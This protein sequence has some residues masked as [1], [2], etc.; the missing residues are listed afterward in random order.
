[1]AD[2][3]TR[4]INA[5]RRSSRKDLSAFMRSHFDVDML[6]A[7]YREYSYLVDHY[8]Q[9][10]QM[11]S[12]A[13]MKVEFPD[14]EY[15]RVNDP[16]DALRHQILDREV[17]NLVRSSVEDVRSLFSD[18][19]VGKAKDL[20]I[21]LGSKLSVGFSDRSDSNWAD[22]MRRVDAYIERAD[23]GYPDAILTGWESFDAATHGFQ[24]GQFIGFG[25][26]P[27]MGKTW[28]LCW[29]VFHAWK[30]KKVPL[31]VS[32]EMS[33]REIEQRIDCIRFGLNYERLRSG[34]LTVAEERRYLWGLENLDPFPLFVIDEGISGAMSI[35][36]EIEERGPDI[37]FVDGV[38]LLKDDQKGKNKAERL[39]NTTSDLKQVA[40]R[41]MVPLVGF[42]QMGREKKG[43]DAIDQIQWSDSFSQDCDI[44]ARIDGDRGA[45]VKEVEMLKQ[46]EGP[47][48]K[49]A[50]RFMPDKGDF[51]EF[52]TPK[53]VAESLGDSVEVTLEDDEV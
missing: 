7:T 37:C 39:Y 12:V 32:M 5:L 15:I 41:T 25:G 45:T 2:L 28:C 43:Y 29:M 26:R 53:E 34:S 20:L 46:R 21:G 50:I 33:I 51:S 4:F 1:V 27:A 8:T 18:G 36:A 10:G 22:G 23:K 19:E 3:E 44:F 48:V 31:V 40:K 17:Q 52:M 24:P 47:L 16:L 14:F 11:P 49:L 38:Y 6:K 35:R 13:S 9:Y 42:T 30:Q